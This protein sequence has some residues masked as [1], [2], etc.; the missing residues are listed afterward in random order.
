MNDE[1]YA[2]LKNILYEIMSEEEHALYKIM[3]EEKHAIL[4]NILYK[5]MND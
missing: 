2:I 3:H 1:D 5:I 4:N